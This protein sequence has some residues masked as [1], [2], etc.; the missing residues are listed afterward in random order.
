MCTCVCLWP[1]S[2]G[3]AASPARSRSARVGA[4]RG[5]HIPGHQASGRDQAEQGWKSWTART[6]KPPLL[7]HCW[8]RGWWHRGLTWGPRPWAGWAGLVNYISAIKA[9]MQYRTLGFK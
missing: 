6:W 9:L 3:L 5:S 7:Q 4:G 8:D 1:G 2:Q